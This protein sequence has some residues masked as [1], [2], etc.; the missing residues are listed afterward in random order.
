[1]GPSGS[2]RGFLSPALP[3]LQLRCGVALLRAS[4]VPGLHRCLLSN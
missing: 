4:R 2:D 3:A 1:M